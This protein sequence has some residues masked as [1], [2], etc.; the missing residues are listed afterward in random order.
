[1][2][3]F[4]DNLKPIVDKISTMFIKVWKW[5]QQ[6]SSHGV[7]S[8]LYLIFLVFFGGALMMIVVATNPTYQ[9]GREKISV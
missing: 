2:T 5:L 7:I 6:Y 4:F 1:M 8:V 9:F 3:G